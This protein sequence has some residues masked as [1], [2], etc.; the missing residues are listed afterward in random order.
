MRRSLG[1]PAGAVIDRHQASIGLSPDRSRCLGEETARRRICRRI[2][3]TSR[4]GNRPVHPDG[5]R[6]ARHLDRLSFDSCRAAGTER[7]RRVGFQAALRDGLAAAHAI[8]ELSLLDPLESRVD[9]PEPR[10]TPA[11]RLYRHRLH[12]YRVHP[13][14]AAHTG[15]VEDNR[16]PRVA[17]LLAQLEKRLAFLEQPRLKRFQIH[18]VSLRVPWFDC[19]LRSTCVRRIT[20]RAAVPTGVGAAPS[21]GAVTRGS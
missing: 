9:A 6:A 16:I 19:A 2:R 18:T 11:L 21:A 17:C 13:R 5:R 4:N 8:A 20:C 1:G 12:L 7:R 14:Q 15:L 3:P 10:L